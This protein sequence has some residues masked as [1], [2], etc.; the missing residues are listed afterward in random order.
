MKERLAAA[1][2]LPSAPAF[3]LPEGRG[4]VKQWSLDEL[5]ALAENPA[6][7]GST[8]QGR[9]WYSA[10]GC[11]ACHTFA[12]EGGAVGADLTAV[13][14]RMSTRELFEAIV[15]PS[16]EISDQY[17]SFVVRRRDGSQVQGRIVNYTPGAIHVSENL[18]EPAVVT[19]IP[20]DE[21][22]SIARSK[23]SLMPA[24]LLNVLEGDEI[25]DLIAYLK[26]GISRP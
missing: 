10:A 3:R 12:G 19:K 8:E 23:A 17:G 13:A 1:K 4:L 9:R 7:R 20:E 18:L 14:A 21:I 22:E 2:S 11:A 26:S 16:K 6:N 24:G 15:D 25:L 5:V